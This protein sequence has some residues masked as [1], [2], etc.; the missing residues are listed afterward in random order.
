MLVSQHSDQGL[1]YKKKK[2]QKNRLLVK[3]EFQVSNLLKYACAI[4]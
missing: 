4:F 3:V 1:S 2:K